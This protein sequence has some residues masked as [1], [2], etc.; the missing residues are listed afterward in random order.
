MKKQLVPCRK[1]LALSGQG[2]ARKQTRGLG[3][4]L[5]LGP[6]PRPGQNPDNP[7][8]PTPEGPPDP[9]LA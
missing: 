4:V 1:V 3:F 9:W 2:V 7:N 8:Q 6:R 5:R